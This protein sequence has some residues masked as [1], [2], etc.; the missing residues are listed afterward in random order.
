MKGDLILRKPKKE[1]PKRPKKIEEVIE[2][3]SEEES[4]K[5]EFFSTKTCS[6][7]NCE[8]TPMSNGLCIDHY[9]EICARVAKTVT[10]KDSEPMKLC[11]TKKR[12]DNLIDGVE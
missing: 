2:N 6:I 5:E 12:L 11:D 8:N 3:V 7:A 10:K 4:W 9:Q 1:K